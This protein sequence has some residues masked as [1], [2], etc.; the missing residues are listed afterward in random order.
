MPSILTR[1]LVRHD[2]RPAPPCS[3]TTLHDRVSVTDKSNWTTTPATAWR[4]GCGTRGTTT[5]LPPWEQSELA[6]VQTGGLH[7]GRLAIVRGNGRREDS[8][9]DN[10]RDVQVLT[11]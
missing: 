1:A 3:I 6:T 10:A 9:G 7:E 4:R 2:P 5:A 8:D 11:I